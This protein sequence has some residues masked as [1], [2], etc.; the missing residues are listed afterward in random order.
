MCGDWFYIPSFGL[1][2]GVDQQELHNQNYRGMSK[3]WWATSMDGKNGSFVGKLGSKLILVRL[4]IIHSLIW[5]IETFPISK[6]CLDNTK[7]LMYYGPIY[8][9]STQINHYTHWVVT[10]N[11]WQILWAT[12]WMK[13]PTLKTSSRL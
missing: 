3:I 7:H 8:S 10:I 6:Q 13:K 9:T 5:H 1:K 12:L 2:N 4:I 11:L